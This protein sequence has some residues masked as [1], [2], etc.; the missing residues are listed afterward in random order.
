MIP[1]VSGET[2]QQGALTQGEPFYVVQTGEDDMEKEDLT[3]EEADVILVDDVMEE[4]RNG[5]VVL[6]VECL[7]HQQPNRI[8]IDKLSSVDTLQVS[9]LAKKKVYFLLST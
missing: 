7:S 3:Q 8:F 5:G 6:N 9:T 4:V 2:E 1:D